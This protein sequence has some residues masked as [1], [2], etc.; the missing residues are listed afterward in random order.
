M[1]IIFI[2]GKSSQVKNWSLNSFQLFCLGLFFIVTV[3]FLALTLNYFSLV[4]A[5]KN[6][7]SYLK[8]MLQVV[9]AEETKE[10][11]IFIRESIDTMAGRL[12][13]MQARLMRLD[14]VGMRVVKLAG[15]DPADLA[16]D[17]NVAL[18]GGGKSGLV[19]DELT[20]V[21]LIQESDRIEAILDDRA[22]KLLMLEERLNLNYSKDQLIPSLKP[23]AKGW[24]SSNFG[25]RIDPFSRKR[26]FHEGVDW[27]S[28]PGS[29]ILAAAGGVV[30]Y[31]RRH[32]QYGN[33]IEID[34]GNGYVT[35][36]AHAEKLAASVGDVVVRGQKVATVGSTGRSTG[37]HLHFEVL[38]NGKPQNPRRFLKR[39]S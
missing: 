22:D 35:R 8:S 13:E 28:K 36:Y 9:H 23:V 32:P 25:W 19:S 2:T 6:Q 16:L 27:V 24:L 5:V 1:D 7:S 37:P 17:K 33:M 34:H 14:S 30:V 11:R 39:S 21:E 10:S 4:Y 3:M 38:K 26:A 20:L 12:G 29:D 15:I 18:G 31:A